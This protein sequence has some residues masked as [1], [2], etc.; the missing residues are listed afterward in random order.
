VVGR[1]SLETMKGVQD[2][3]LWVC[4]QKSGDS[5]R[6]WR[7]GQGNK[8]GPEANS[9]VDCGKAVAVSMELSDKSDRLIRA[10]R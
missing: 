4:V 1:C 3:L 6:E 9:H 5:K 10:N 7:R 2:G 8:W